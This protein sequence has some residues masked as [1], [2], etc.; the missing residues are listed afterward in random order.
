MQE[1]RVAIYVQGLDKDKIAAEV[2][3]LSEYIVN[4][5]CTL[6]SPDQVFVD[7]DNSFKQLAKLVKQM[8][9]SDIKAVYVVHD[10]LGEGRE[11]YRNL[12]NDI[13]IQ[14]KSILVCE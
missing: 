12:I 2:K 14:G 3:K 6:A 1:T 5:G 4:D 8:P 7:T 9:D 13:Y 10:L 11:L